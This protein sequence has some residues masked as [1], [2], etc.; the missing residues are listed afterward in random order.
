[1]IMRYF[2]IVFTGETALIQA[3]T[4]EPVIGESTIYR[5]A[6]K[7]PKKEMRSL[8]EKIDKQINDLPREPVNFQPYLTPAGS[9]TYINQNAGNGTYICR[10]CGRP[11]P[12]GS[13]F[14]GW[15]GRGI[16]FQPL[17]YT[18]SAGYSVI[19]D[20][21][22]AAKKSEKKSGRK[23]IGIFLAITA[24]VA[25][26]T[27]AVIAVVLIKPFNKVESPRYE[28]NSE[29]DITKKRYTMRMTAA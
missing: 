1:M 4:R 24:A 28:Y 10:N 3:W 23:W 27:F 29:G 9:G 5:G 2:S 16:N 22:S 13:R 15:C 11:I 21:P 8:L 20:T 6:H 14:C 25:V 12:A 19:S 18:G 17:P 7:I 26:I